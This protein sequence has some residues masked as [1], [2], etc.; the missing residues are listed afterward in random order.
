MKKFFLFF[1]MAVM[2]A[3]SANAQSVV[4]SYIQMPDYAYYYTQRDS[5]TNFPVCLLEGGTRNCSVEWGWV[6]NYNPKYSPS[7]ALFPNSDIT[8]PTVYHALRVDTAYTLESDPTGASSNPIL[9]L[10]SEFDVR[11]FYTL[12]LDETF[13]CRVYQNDS[14]LI[15]GMFTYMNEMQVRNLWIYMDG[16][17]N[18]VHDGDTV[19]Y[20][21][22]LE[23]DGPGQ[24][25]EVLIE[26]YNV[27]DTAEAYPVDVFRNGNSYYAKVVTPFD[28]LFMPG[29]ILNEKTQVYWGGAWSGDQGDIHYNNSGVLRSPSMQVDDVVWDVSI[30]MENGGYFIHSYVNV[31]RD[32]LIVDS[33]RLE[34][35]TDVIDWMPLM[36]EDFYIDSTSISGF[37]PALAFRAGTYYFRFVAVAGGREYV[38]QVYTVVIG[39]GINI[40]LE[41]VTEGVVEYDAETN[42]VTIS[43]AVIENVVTALANMQD[44]VTINLEGI[45]TM[46]AEE[47][48]ILTSADIVIAGSYGEGFVSTDT[49]TISAPRPIVAS[50]EG[51]KITFD[52]VTL[53]LVVP[54]HEGDVVPGEVAARRQMSPMMR[55]RYIAKTVLLAQE[56]GEES[57]VS[58]FDEADFINCGIIEPEGA[59]YDEDNLELMDDGDPVYNCT[60]VPMD[61]PLGV[62]NVDS[63]EEKVGTEKRVAG[64]MVLI[65]RQ[66]RVY[67]VTGQLVK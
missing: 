7:D 13:Y 22:S 41:N 51:V 23:M 44:G 14:V 40:D 42:T 60:I 9:M 5:M 66:N 8:K 35:A 6:E 65:M 54:G 2:T 62:E 20:R 28:S 29:Y 48:G 59:E 31:N 25:G 47:N 11:P 52:G 16:L 27:R 19:P 46:T 17:Y 18:G 12:S 36:G 32:S 3:L 1:V 24:G 4:P 30:R 49:M 50:A 26:W 67:T 39:G 55:A 21:A 61:I 10:K 38:S 58:G 15:E 57:V 63:K 45:T 33:L 43:D 56:T 34:M 64:G 37:L 53:H